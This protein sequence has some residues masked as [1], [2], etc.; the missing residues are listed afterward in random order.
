MVFS[1][2]TFPCELADDR[3]Y[4]RCANEKGRNGRSLAVN[5][6][7][8]RALRL[9]RRNQHRRA[10]RAARR[11]RFAK[12]PNRREPCFLE[13][14]GLAC[15]RLSFDRREASSDDDEHDDAGGHQH[16]GLGEI[17]ESV[18]YR[19]GDKWHGAGNHVAA[20]WMNA[21]RSPACSDHLHGPQHHG[22][23]NASLA[24]WLFAT[25]WRQG[26]MQRLRTRA[27]AIEGGS[28]SSVTMPAKLGSAWQRTDMS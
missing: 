25:V 23:L 24:E 13:F 9:V 7:C 10:E 22:T 15:D 14:C 8:R 1:E 12:F 18:L 20:A 5:I 19:S 3:V 17:I 26:T 4:R 27:L 11:L 28:V 16:P 2:E 6:K 21:A